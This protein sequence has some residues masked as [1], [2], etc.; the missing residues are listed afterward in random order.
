[1]DIEEL[2]FDGVNWIEVT[3]NRKQC[4]VPF[5]IVMKLWLPIADIIT[6]LVP[7]FFLV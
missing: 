6:D 3:Q 1:V 2:H 5:L 4:W 7:F